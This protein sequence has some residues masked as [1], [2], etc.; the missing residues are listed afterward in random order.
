MGLPGYILERRELA[1]VCGGAT[2]S[3]PLRCPRAV[4]HLRLAGSR[5][6]ERCQW[7]QAWAREVDKRGC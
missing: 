5:R 3:R 2:Q 7:W 4:P 1:S 6:E